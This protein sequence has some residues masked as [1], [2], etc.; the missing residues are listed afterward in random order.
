MGATVKFF[1]LPYLVFSV[2]LAL[3][4]LT[5]AGMCSCSTIQVVMGTRVRLEKIPVISMQANL[6]R[7]PAMFPGEKAPLVVR[8]KELDGKL[9]LTEGAGKGK[10][11]WDDLRITGKIVNVDKNG[12][13]TMPADPRL[14]DGKVPHLTITVPSHPDIA[15]EL[16]IPLRYDHSF[17]ANFSGHAGISGMDG[18][19]GMAGSS[20]SEGSVDGFNPSP[21]GDGS[22]GSDGSDGQDGRPGK[23]APSVQV[24]LTMMS[25]DRPLLQVSISAAG[26]DEYYLVDPVGGSLTVKAEGGAGGP[27][28]KGGRGGRGGSGGAGIPSGFRGVDGSDGHDGRS[29]PAGRGGAITVRFDPKT[30][31]YLSL[32]HFSTRDGDG[33]P[34]PVPVFTEEPISLLW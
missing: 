4:C 9:L 31:Q 30:K 15:S 27:G 7:G 34:G 2:K 19:S 6:P 12:T 25:G 20:G 22:N 29:G 18:T 13:V 16:D 23:D 21:G 1:S 5:V 28:G 11:L 33:R 10:V 26:R 14:S 32:F 3:F 24:R 8:F 17:T